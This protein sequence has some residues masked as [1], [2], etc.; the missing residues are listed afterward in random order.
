MSLNHAVAH[1]TIITELELRGKEGNECVQFLLGV[2]KNYKAEGEQY[3]KSVPIPVKAFGQRA[4]FITEY[5]KKLDQII[6]EGEIDKD[7]DYT[8]EDGTVIRGGIYLKVNA[9][10]FSGKKES[11]GSG[12]SEGS[13]PAA[14][15]APAKTSGLS[16]PTN[17][18]GANAPTKKPGLG[19][20]PKLGK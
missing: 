10:Y 19:G 14:K 9:S 5:F 16:K 18:L 15:A 11:G 2:N 20:L 12:A 8:K 3:P 6:V 17:G 4:V 13:A 1:G 7:D